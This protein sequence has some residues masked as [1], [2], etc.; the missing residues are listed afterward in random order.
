M[1]YVYIRYDPSMVQFTRRVFP[2]SYRTPIDCMY[3]VAF[4]APRLESLIRNRVK[5]E[6]LVCCDQLLENVNVLSQW[7][8]A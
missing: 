2:M 6:I 1:R 5:Y 7:Q 3:V 8:K 4:A